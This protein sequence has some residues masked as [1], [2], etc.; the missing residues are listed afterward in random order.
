MGPKVEAAI[1]FARHCGHDAVIGAL[2]DL[3]AI[4]AGNAG[5]RVSLSAV[6]VTYRGERQ[7]HASA[8]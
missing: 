6:G 1:Q 7:E 2:R 3:P 5:T 8:A 4:L